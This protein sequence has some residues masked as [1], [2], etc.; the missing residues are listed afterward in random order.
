MVESESDGCSWAL[1]GIF[2]HSCYHHDACLR[3]W[4]PLELKTE[5]ECD[6]EFYNNLVAACDRHWTG[7]WNWYC[8]G[9]I[10]VVYRTFGGLGTS[11][12]VP[13]HQIHPSYHEG[14]ENY[15]TKPMI[16]AC[17]LSTRFA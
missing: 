2:A 1:D 6:T 3:Y 10:A 12:A 5:Y 7:L 13:W 4:A 14:G 11:S 17:L 9:V 15:P 16:C 8:V